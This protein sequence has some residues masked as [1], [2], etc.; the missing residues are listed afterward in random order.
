MDYLLTRDS[1]HTRVYK[2]N[3]L[4]LKPCFLF[5]CSLG[6]FQPTSAHFRNEE[7]QANQIQNLLSW[8]ASQRART[9]RGREPM[10][11]QMADQ[12]TA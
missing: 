1:Q 5:L 9:L 2:R 10:T 8:K 4:V 12:S 11:M 6:M 7:Y 3:W